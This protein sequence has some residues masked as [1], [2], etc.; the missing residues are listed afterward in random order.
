MPKFISDVQMQQT[1]NSLFCNNEKSNKSRRKFWKGCSFLSALAVLSTYFHSQLLMCVHESSFSVAT[2]FASTSVNNMSSCI[3][4]D[5]KT[6]S[7][8]QGVFLELGDTWRYPR[9]TTFRLMADTISNAPRHVYWIHQK[10]CIS[11]QERIQNIVSRVVLVDQ[12]FVRQT[13]RLQ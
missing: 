6:D 2:V 10:Y 12:Q 8:R 7:E 5:V 13:L 1:K 11:L 4:S 3:L 9:A